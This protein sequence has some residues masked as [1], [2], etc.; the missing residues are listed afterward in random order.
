MKTDNIL[1][2]SD[3]RKLGYAEYGDPKGRPLFFFHGWPGSRYAAKLI[4]QEAKKQGLRVIAPDRP[5]MGLSDYKEFRKFLDWPDDVTELADSLRI[6]KFS[7]LGVSG[8]GPY[9][10]ACAYKTPHRV[11][12]VS[13]VAGV[14]PFR[15]IQTLT[16]RQKARMYGI[17]LLARFVGIQLWIYRYFFRRHPDLSAT[18]IFKIIFGISRKEGKKTDFDRI[19]M[20]SIV[21]AMRQGIRGPLWEIGLYM[22]RTWGFSL[23]DIQHPIHLWHSRKDPFV[24]VTLAAYVAQSL[25]VCHAV[26]VSE[27]G[28]APMLY[29]LTDVLE[30]I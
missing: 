15:E 29:Y 9:A 17:L 12:H 26:F 8:G 27:G 11:R 10:L 4:D 7:I 22:R 19:L 30:Q 21:E 18:I 2:L 3:G 25:P 5:G 20:R 28:H 23:R 6:K 13:V 14:G 16:L 1:R 24:P